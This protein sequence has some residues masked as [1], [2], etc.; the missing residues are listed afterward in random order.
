MNSIALSGADFKAAKAE[1]FQVVGRADSPKSNRTRPR[2]VATY[3][4]TDEAGQLL[5][6]AV[7]MDPKDFRQRKA[8]GKGGWEWSIKDVRLVLYRLPELLGRAD[9][10]VFVCEGEKDVDALAALGALATCNPMGAGKWR[11]GFSEALKGRSVVILPDNDKPGRVHA[12]KVATDLLSVGCDVRIVEVP[13]AKDVSDWLAAGATLADIQGLARNQPVL[14]SGSLAE[15]LTRWGLDT[16]APDAK[17][18]HLPKSSPFRVTDDSVLYID[19]DPDKEPLMIVPPSRSEAHLLYS[20]RGSRCPG[21]HDARPYGPH[22]PGNAGALQPHSHGG[23]AG[24]TG[25]NH[26]ASRDREFGRGPCESPCSG[27]GGPN[28]I[29]RNYLKNLVGPVGFEPTT[30]GL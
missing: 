8:D 17:P 20:A 18:E 6:Q 7:R 24:S 15:L 26:P 10:C 14:S 21:I 29:A 1:V 4:Y 16:T 30:N 27:A 2:I 12:A 13:K 5:Y 11:A 9:E 25:H 28:S 22:E 19:P 23:Q 3:D